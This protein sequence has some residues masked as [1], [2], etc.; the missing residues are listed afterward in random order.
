V[1]SSPPR[2]ND[3]PKKYIVMLEGRNFILDYE[4]EPTRFGF[5]TTRHV[6]AADPEEAE[7]RAIQDVQ[8]DDQ[9]NASLLNDPSNPPRVTMTR[10]IEV[11]SFESDRSPE[12]GY[13]FYQDHDTR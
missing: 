1:D 12:L 5:S 3:L 13:I 9:L 2:A 6:E 10:A 11:E 8:R 7:Q 4:G